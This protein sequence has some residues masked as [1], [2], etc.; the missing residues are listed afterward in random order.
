MPTRPAPPQA[1]DLG[2][3]GLYQQL[4]PLDVDKH[5]L[6]DDIKRVEL[7]LEIASDQEH[8][9]LVKAGLVTLESMDSGADAQTH[10]LRKSANELSQPFLRP[11]HISDLPDEVLSTIFGA[12]R[13]CTPCWDRS[14]TRV[15]DQISRSLSIL[16]GLS[17]QA[18]AQQSDV[19]G[20]WYH[21]KGQFFYMEL[22]L[23]N[24]IPL[25]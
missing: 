11:L 8:R 16:Q 10:Q 22:A 19:F 23:R 5:R 2:P 6:H 20:P 3:S 15:S 9:Q 24:L 25:L 4:S 12:L 13:G 14:G 17:S 7:T 1:T 18:L 21:H